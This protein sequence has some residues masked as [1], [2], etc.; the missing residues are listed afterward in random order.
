MVA[1]KKIAF[2]DRDGVINEPI[3]IHGKPFAPTKFEQF[4]VLPKVA[5]S[6]RILKDLG[7][8]TVTVTNQPDISLGRQNL[9]ELDAI[10]SF[11]LKNYAIDLIKVCIHTDDHGCKCRKPKPGMLL[12]VAMKYEISIDSCFM[13][14]DRWRDVEAG[15]RAGCGTNFY[16]DYKYL[17]KRPSGSFETVNSL[18]DCVLTIAKM[19][20]GVS[21]T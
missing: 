20:K 12:E 4:R 10:H 19:T 14:G 15:Q 21:K 6:L 16:I 18:H 1:P 2:L 7:F 5:D 11:L 8:L 17:E 13:I 9:D 3:V